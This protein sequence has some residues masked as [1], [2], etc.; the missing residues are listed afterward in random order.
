MKNYYILTVDSFQDTFT[1]ID[2]GKD[3]YFELSVQNITGILSVLQGGDT[4]IVYRKSPVSG[5]TIV[6]QVVE[7]AGN[8]T[9]FRK[10]FEIGNVVNPS[11]PDHDLENEYL[12]EISSDVYG[13]ICKQMLDSIQGIMEVNI[14]EEEHQNNLKQRFEQYILHVLKLKSTRQV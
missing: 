6:L 7:N 10:V 14:S 3:F 11:V 4:V 1:R 13:V 9:K 5:C 2:A 12:V 8:K